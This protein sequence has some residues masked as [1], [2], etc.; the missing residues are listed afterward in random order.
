MITDANRYYGAVFSKVIDFS[1]G[2]VSMQRASADYAGFYILQKNIP[3]YI[4]Y[5]T[6]RR[7]PWTFNFFQKPQEFQE[8]LYAKYGECITIFVCGKDGIAALRHDEFRTVLDHIFEEQEAVTIRRKHNKMY[9]V[10]GKNGALERKV[11]RSSLEEAFK[12]IEL[13]DGAT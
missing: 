13:R 8:S 2:G 4:K 1:G 12:N 5:S 3:I 11:S 7:G 6:S 9:S 10:R